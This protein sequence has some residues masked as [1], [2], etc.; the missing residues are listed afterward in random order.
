LLW[1]DGHD[2]GTGEDRPPLVGDLAGDGATEFLG[3]RC[4]CREDKRDDA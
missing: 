1:A 2:D 3:I 4:D